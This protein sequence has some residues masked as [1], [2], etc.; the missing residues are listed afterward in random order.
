MKTVA[1]FSTL[2]ASTLAQGYFSVM[3]AR[4]ASP[5]HLLPLNAIGG[6]FFLGGSPSSYCPP[7][8]GDACQNY[9]GNDTVLAGGDATLSLGVV[10]PGGQQGSCEKNILSHGFC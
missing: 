3:S 8:I 1:A 2:M 7:S 10:V 6:K 9:P 4:S 5:I